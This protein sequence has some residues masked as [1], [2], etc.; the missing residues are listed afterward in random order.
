[1]TVEF[2]AGAHFNLALPIRPLGYMELRLQPNSL[3]LLQI[4]DCCNILNGSALLMGGIFAG[5]L[6]IKEGTLSKFSEFNC[7][8]GTIP[9]VWQVIGGLWE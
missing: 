5:I 6:E 4:R 8:E 1:M 2:T 9:H 7:F 3:Q